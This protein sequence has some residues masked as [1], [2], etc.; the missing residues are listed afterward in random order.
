MADRSSRS[1][2]LLGSAVVLA[3]V[4]IGAKVVALAP[5]ALSLAA[6]SDALVAS[7]EDILLVLESACVARVLLL[8]TRGRGRS[9][10]WGL[11]VGYGVV[12]AAYAVIACRT[13]TLL[14]VPITYH[15]LV[16]A[17]GVG[18]IWS[19]V[20]GALSPGFVISLLSAPALF[21]LYAT[22]RV[23]P[24]TGSALIPRLGALLVVVLG[25]VLVQEGAL[26]YERT[27]AARLDRPIAVSPHVT[28]VRSVLHRDSPFDHPPSGLPDRY[29]PSD[30][31]DF[32]IP[33]A[34][35][36]LIA[37]SKPRGIILYVLESTGAEYLDVY[38]GTYGVSPNL[39]RIA[40]DGL[41]VSP[42]YANLGR[43]EGALVTLVLSSYLPLTWRPFTE[44]GQTPEGTT[45]AAALR[46]KGF[47]TA[48]LSAGDLGYVD[49][50]A[51]LHADGNRGFDTIV[52][53]QALGCPTI[54][55]WGVSDACVV[56]AALREIDQHPDRPFFLVVWTNQT[57]HP[58]PLPDDVP[59]R[60]FEHP[61]VPTSQVDIDAYLNTVA[62]GDRQLGRL[63]DGL[64][65]R[66]I[67][68][69]VLFTV[70]GDHSE[71]FGQRHPAFRHGF[72]LYDEE[73][74]IPFVLHWP[75]GLAQRGQLQT[76][77][78]QLDVT[79]TLAHLAGL[80][81]APSWYGRSVFDPS[82]PQRA[83]LFASTGP[84]VVGIRTEAS[85]YIVNVLDGQ[86]ELYDVVT[87][88]GEQH[89]L[90]LEQPA[91]RPP[92]RSRLAAWIWT[93][94]TIWHQGEL[95]LRHGDGAE[96]VSSGGP[97]GTPSA[98]N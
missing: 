25:L 19:A 3:L 69:D 51:F 7:H 49:Q 23:R 40:K 54:S 8:I 15:L 75:N 82:R 61:N 83:Y 12:V 93:D 32:A 71:A 39:D 58:Y 66:G 88:P 94:R 56:T 97:E 98:A 55:T 92:L 22:R 52:D 20:R 77:T 60:T 21:A 46:A 79:P 85:M 9:V 1:F 31:A 5:K 65:A 45:L 18:G 11:W 10:V 26:R 72:H 57:H 34:S 70:I 42:A 90:V 67:A 86:D 38:G 84:L 6:A 41:V 81:Q 74:R 37:T 87:D 17:G 53:G 63:F 29:A 95:P 73:M 2:P 59:K 35:P 28:F 64:V 47:H 44:G 14:W 50:R 91:A 4:L 62:E 24:R 27:W 36:P 13:Y 80:P 78:S 16:I 48:L 76:V 96:G 30:L 68:D 33:F 43:T 89:N